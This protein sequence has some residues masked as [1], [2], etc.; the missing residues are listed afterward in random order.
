MEE[1]CIGR[2]GTK[3]NIAYEVEE[4]KEEE[5]EEEEEE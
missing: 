4:E 1:A 3:W 2:Q 5:N